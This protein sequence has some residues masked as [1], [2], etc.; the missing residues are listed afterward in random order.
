MKNKKLSFI[1][2]IA[3]TMAF[4]SCKK[5]QKV[6]TTEAKEVIE[7]VSSE[8]YIASATETFITWNAKKKVLGGHQGTINA[9]SGVIEVKGKDVVGGHF[10]IDLNTINVTDI[11][12]EGKKGNLIGHLKNVDFFDV[13]NHPNGAFEI[14]SV[15]PKNDTSIIAGNL[16]LKGIKKNIAFPATIVVNG[17]KTMIKSEEFNIDRTEWGINYNSGKVVDPASLGDKLI[18]DEVGIVVN[19]IASK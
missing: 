9:S 18:K 7:V 3:L 11:E 16:T 2:L 13:A 17:G 4:T 8:T 12:E 15:T 1:A 6:A 10:I 14:T 5:E 19:I